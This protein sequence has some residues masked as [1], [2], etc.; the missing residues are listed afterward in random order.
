MGDLDMKRFIASLIF[1]A[2]H[3]LILGDAIAASDSINPQVDHKFAIYLGGF[4]PEVS[5]EVRL[6]G[7][8]L[9]PGDKLD[10]ENIFGLEESKTVLWG[11]ARWHISRRN[12]LEFEF[13][14]LNRNGTV[15]G[16]TEPI[17]I[18]DT[19]VQ[20]GA[21]INTTFDVTLGRLTYG[22]S[23][24]KNEKMDL[25]LKAGVHIADLG[26]SF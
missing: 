5:S 9:P 16:I 20:V 7:D 22:F 15:E 6:N 11:G 23:V 13:A 4:F 17:Q 1:V 12:V 10:F 14:N 19:I 3:S 2:L 21:R 25:K 18:E 8:I 26:V 24:L